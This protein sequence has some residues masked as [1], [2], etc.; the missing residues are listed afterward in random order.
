MSTLTIIKF[1]GSHT[2]HEHIIETMNIAARL[3]SMGM[4][5]N[6]NFLVTLSLTPYLL[7]MVHFT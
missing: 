6:E 7:S 5:V 4:E 2:I 1:D 3:K